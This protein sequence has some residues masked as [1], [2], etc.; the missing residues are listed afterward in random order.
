[1][2]VRGDF[3]KL[4]R[5]ISRLEQLERGDLLTDLNRNLAEEAV[6]LVREGFERETDPYGARWA[7]LKYRSGRILQDTGRLRSSF[8]VSRVNRRGFRVSASVS[9]A[10]YHQTG[11]S[12]GLVPR[13]MVP[14]AGLP[15]RWRSRLR[16]VG[17]DFLKSRLGG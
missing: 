12:R 10:S 6:E 4:A 17:R 15:A 5:L 2:A 16:D 11:T 9:H 8:K 1:M 7:A 13:R 3:A 14:H